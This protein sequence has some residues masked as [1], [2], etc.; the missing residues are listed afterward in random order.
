M[1]LNRGDKT[2]T[3]DERFEVDEINIVGQG[4]GINSN[5]GTAGQLLKKNAIDNSI[6][7]GSG[8]NAT[9]TIQGAGANPN[10]TTF[11][12]SADA[13]VNIASN[14]VAAPITLNA[15]EIGF[16]GTT[17]NLSINTINNITAGV[18]TAVN[19]FLGNL[20]LSTN[21]QINYDNQGQ[22]EQ[23]FNAATM[24][25]ETKGSIIANEPSTSATLRK[26]VVMGP[27]AEKSAILN[28]EMNNLD[29][30]NSGQTTPTIT[31]FT[32]AG[33]PYVGLDMGTNS[34]SN[35]QEAVANK[36]VIT[37][38]QTDGI[39]YGA[40]GA[41][42]VLF[43]PQTG[44]L[45]TIGNITANQSNKVA[46][47]RKLV[48]SGPLAEKSE[49]LHQ[50]V[51]TVKFS[52]NGADQPDLTFA[53]G[54]GTGIDMGGRDIIGCAN[55]VCN[56]LN[57]SNGN[58]NMG[59][60]DLG[61]DEIT[62]GDIAC[63]GLDLGG[64]DI[65]NVGDIENN[66]ITAVGNITSN[67]GNIIATQ[68]NI[69]A[70]YSGQ[71]S[72]FHS[73]ETQPNTMNDADFSTV[74][75]LYTQL[76][77]LKEI[78]PNYTPII[79]W[80]PYSNN[81]QTRINLQGGSIIDGADGSFTRVKTSTSLLEVCDSKNHTV[82]FR[83]RNIELSDV[84]D[85]ITYITKYTDR[86]VINTEDI[87]AGSGNFEYN[88]N[89]MSWFVADYNE[90]GTGPFSPAPQNNVITPGIR[91]S[92][93]GTGS[94]GGFA[95]YPHMDFRGPGVAGRRVVYSKR[96]PETGLSDIERVV[97]RVIQ[98]SSSNGGENCDSGDN[99]FMVW[100]NN[101]G[102]F[103]SLPDS[104]SAASNDY[105]IQL[106]AGSST[107][108]H[109]WTV[110]TYTLTNDFTA[111][112]KT[113]FQQARRIAFVASHTGSAVSDFDHYGLTDIYFQTQNEQTGLG[114]FTKMTAGPAMIGKAS[115]SNYV[116]ANNSG[117][118]TLSGGFAYYGLQYTNGWYYEKLD[119][120]RWIA[121]DDSDTP[122]SL[123]LF[124]PS[125]S[126][127]TYPNSGSI[128]NTGGLVC[129][130]GTHT[131][132]Y[133]PFNCPPGYAIV[134]YYI[135]LNDVNGARINPDTHNSSFYNSMLM[136]HSGSSNQQGLNYSRIISQPT[137]SNGNP[138]NSATVSYMGFN[139]EHAIAHNEYGNTYPVFGPC[140]QGFYGVEQFGS[141]SDMNNWKQYYL[142]LYA[143]PAWS[144]T[145]RIKGGYIKYRR[146]D[147]AEAGT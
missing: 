52:I 37:D 16:D 46:S 111:T 137:D 78:T 88:W 96:F 91:Q 118:A 40:A 32:N 108:Y 35:I 85:D 63:S 98:G 11:D 115:N 116:K 51:N 28:V 15:G 142:H 135:T 120:G 69:Q 131:Q 104:N 24:L 21:K 110:L 4:I 65:E 124:E 18:I 38:T 58:I 122:S 30:N 75:T 5:F 66:S 125:V 22:V 62:A 71:K 127:S 3:G 49:I 59:T 42:N 44:D 8:L 77:T 6:E 73:I 100:S 31:F 25:L 144:N 47:F 143:S 87:Q 145:M 129:N 74:K 72:L 54:T 68:G 39:V 43:N 64:G 23:L 109:S 139:R 95:T 121:D 79:S 13:V 97:L 53:A 147:R 12:G 132:I 102:S 9:L 89:S 48:V 1:S 60:G 70:T 93:T 2:L 27:V 112:Q 33:V 130:S 123:T 146:L 56:F 92:G 67:T 140:F 107:L 80:D 26:I 141:Y 76:L 84:L 29:M 81:A 41:T 83:N 94:T 119:L 82:R 105:W 55:M 36:L 10:P 7:W 101:L 134:A 19:N 138:D 99:L 20:D 128:D 113:N 61:C 14:T 106:V 57:T 126:A 136:C 34:I 103:A 133:Y 17:G 45:D 50:E 90:M 117:L 86:F 114:N